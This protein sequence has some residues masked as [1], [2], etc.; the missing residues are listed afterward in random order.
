MQ[1]LRVHGD[2]D[3]IDVCVFKHWIGLA[4]LVDDASGE[5]PRVRVCNK[6]SGHV[7]WVYSDFPPRSTIHSIAFDPYCTARTVTRSHIRSRS[8]MAEYFCYL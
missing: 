4:E 7:E 5:R 8:L 1:S 2:P 6:D 3:E